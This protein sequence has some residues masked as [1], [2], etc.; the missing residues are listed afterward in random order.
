MSPLTVL[1]LVLCTHTQLLSGNKALREE[2]ASHL[3]QCPH[4]TYTPPQVKPGGSVVVQ[5]RVCEVAGMPFPLIIFLK[6][7]LLILCA[8]VG[9]PDLTRTCNIH[10][11]I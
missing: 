7:P 3:N 10:P 2:C 9:V 6:V 11:F 5:L 4:L 8:R 1:V